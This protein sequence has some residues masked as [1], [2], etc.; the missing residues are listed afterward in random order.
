MKLVG[1]M[2]IRPEK[3]NSLYLNGGRLVPYWTSKIA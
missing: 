3:N 1:D 2:T